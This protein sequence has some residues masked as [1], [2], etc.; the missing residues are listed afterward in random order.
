MDEDHNV[1]NRPLQ[2]EP[3]SD[4]TLN[5]SVDDHEDTNTPKINVKDVNDGGE[6]GVSQDLLSEDSFPINPKEAQSET[7]GQRT[8][9]FILLEDLTAGMGKP[10]VLDL[11][12]G[13]RQYGVDANEKKILSQRTK[14]ASTT[15]QQLG[16]RICGMQSFN[17]KTGESLY[18]DKYFGR[19]VEAGKPFRMALTRFLYDGI[20]YDSVAEHIPSILKKLSK[21]ENMVRRLPGY[22]FYASSLL[23]YYDAEPE[24]S[25]EYIEAEKNGVDLVKQKKEHNK[26]WP[27]PI[28]IK[29]VDFANCVTSEDPLPE[30]VKAPPHHPGDIDRGY[31]RGL[32]SLKYYFT[33]ILK[34]IESG[35]YNTS[36]PEA[37]EVKD[38]EED[39]LPLS[40][41][42]S[43]SDYVPANF[44]TEDDG[45]VSI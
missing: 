12:M 19:A 10:C 23:M 5:G 33:R 30:G 3:E 32:R 16:V 8:A 42:E 13:T 27:P 40:D 7:P 21:L 18:Q 31:L 15:S 35:K 14:C 45:A 37:A 43:E 26:V 4:S 20:S 39:A 24:K 29:L 34:D 36:K 6:E 41:T 44:E 9:Y 22:R 17:R 28:E 2:K 1:T 11:K 38:G 25:R